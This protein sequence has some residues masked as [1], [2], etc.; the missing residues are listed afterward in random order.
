[1]RVYSRSHEFTCGID[2]HARTMFLCVL[3][4]EGRAVV[5]RNLP[6]RPDAFLATIAPYRS[7][8]VVGCECLFAWYWL[9]DLCEQEGIEFVLGHALGMRAIYGLKTKNDKLD[10]WKIA[11]LLRGGNLPMA[12]VYPRRFRATRDLLRRR[13]HFVRFRTKSND[14][15]SALRKSLSPL[16]YLDILASTQASDRCRYHVRIGHDLLKMSGVV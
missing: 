16:S 10:S 9:A 4:R 8:L 14:G 13:L 6:C 7:D 2:L 1:M 3:Y 11:Q 15:M 12:Y 5:H